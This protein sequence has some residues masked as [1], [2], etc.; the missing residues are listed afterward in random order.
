MHHE[1]GRDDIE[2]PLGKILYETNGWISNLRFSPKGD[3]IAFMDHP[4]RWDN[5]G[6]VAATDLNGRRRTLTQKWAIEDGLAW[7][8]KGDEIWFTASE[9]GGTAGALWAVTPSGRLRKV[10]S[11]PGGLRIQDIAA[12]GR[13]L[14]TSDTVRLAMEFTGKTQNNIK[15]LSWYDWTIAKDISA[16]GQWVLFE[17]GGEPVGANDAIAIRKVDGSPPVR[18]G[19]GTAGSLSPDGKWAVAIPRG[20]PSHLTLLSVGAGQSREV[21]LPGLGHIQSGAHFLPDGR[22]IVFNASEPGRPSRTF[23]VDES[24]GKL[25]PITPEGVYA[26]M[27]SPDGKYL[28]G[29]SPEHQIILFPLDGGAPRSVPGAHPKYEVA[30]W[31]SDSKAL[32]IYRPDEVPLPVQRLDVATGK[33]KPIRTLVPADRAGVVSIAPVVTN[34]QASEFAYSYYQATSIL[35]VISG[36]R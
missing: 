29:I 12:D 11:A 30:Q 6:F 7:S 24:G 21:P 23:V 13:I 33:M 26:G 8:P 1:N 16:D 31:S 34:S 19:E 36:L 22:R 2:Y 18:L 10:L 35:Y 5:A 25:Q 15:D 14:T 28:A 9:S 20:A 17:E 4:V 3:E 27:A 32:Y